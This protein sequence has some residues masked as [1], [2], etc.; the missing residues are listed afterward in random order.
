MRT[1]VQTS[2]TTKSHF[3]CGLNDISL[4]CKGKC[5][6]DFLEMQNRSITELFLVPARGFAEL[7]LLFVSIAVVERL[8]NEARMAVSTLQPVFRRNIDFPSNYLV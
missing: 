8:D 4:P 5:G 7:V 3:I 1:V 2:S 6:I